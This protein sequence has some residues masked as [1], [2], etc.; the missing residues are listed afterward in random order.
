M[1]PTVSPPV[2]CD[3]SAAAYDETSLWEISFCMAGQLVCVSVWGLTALALIRGGSALLKCLFC[4]RLQ[5]VWHLLVCVVCSTICC[6]SEL[7]S[8][9]SS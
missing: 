1:S 5:I 7:P 4:I 3:R 9:H 2:N 6:T 8:N